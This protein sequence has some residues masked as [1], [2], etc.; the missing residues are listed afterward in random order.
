M[1]WKLEVTGASTDRVVLGVG[2]GGVGWGV[3]CHRQRPQKS[4]HG[5]HF[6]AYKNVTTKTFLL[7][8][9][10]VCVRDCPLWFCAKVQIFPCQTSICHL[11]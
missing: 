2:W 6:L 11:N 3:G 7:F 9:A 1:T 8:F 10:V 5:M 4:F